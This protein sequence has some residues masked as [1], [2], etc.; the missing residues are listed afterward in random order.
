MISGAV[1]KIVGLVLAHSVLIGS[2]LQEGELLVPVV[3]YQ[4]GENRS[5]KTFEADTQEEAVVLGQEF[6]NSLS[7]KSDSWAYVQDGLITLPNGNKQDVY[8]IK[9]WA[10]GMSEPMELYQMYTAQPFT[11]I[12]NIK[13]LNYADTGLSAEDADSFIAALEQGI[14]SHPSASKQDLEKWFK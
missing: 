4:Q 12:E 9:A 13:V 1:G 3:T 11:L 10:K 7:D 6:L 14:Y 2:E 8:Y 5:I